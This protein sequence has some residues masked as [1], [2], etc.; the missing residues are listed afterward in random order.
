DSMFDSLF[1]EIPTDTAL[2]YDSFFFLDYGSV[3]QV[4]D[5]KP[6]ASEDS[7][8]NTSVEL[9]QQLQK[10]KNTTLSEIVDKLQFS[11]TD[12]PKKAITRILSLPPPKDRLK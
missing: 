4:D 9:S 10:T 3:E 6:N 2:K 8:G 11:F 12:L 5:L 7:F 1:S